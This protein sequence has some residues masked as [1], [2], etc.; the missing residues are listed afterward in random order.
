MRRFKS[1]FSV[2]TALLILSGLVAACSSDA[3][4]RPRPNEGPP[5]TG[6]GSTSFAVTVSSNASELLVGTNATDQQSAI[7]TVSVRRSDNGQ[8][9]PNG[10]TVVVTTN[11]GSFGSPGSGTTSVVLPLTNGGAAI[12]LFGGMVLGT[13]IVQASISGSV[14]SVQIQIVEEVAFALNFL[15]PNSG[16]P[17]GGETVVVNGQGFQ[18]PVQIRFGFRI[19]NPDGSIRFD[20]STAQAVAITPTQVT[21]VTPPSLATVGVGDTAIVN[22]EFTN[23][24]GTANETTRTLEGAF[25]YA[26][27]GTLVRPVISSI[28]PKA[29]PNEG[30]TRI[31]ILGDGFESPVQVIFGNGASPAGFQGVEATIES[32]TRGELVVVTPSATGVGQDNRNSF[33][34]ILV[35]NQSSGFATIEQAGF[36]YGQS[37]VFVSSISPGQGPHFGGT[38]VTI[39]GSGFDEPV[40]VSFA[41]VAASI[42]SVTGSEI[43]ARTSGVVLTSC[44]NVEGPTEVVNIE[45]SDGATGPDFIYVVA[46]PVVSSIVPSDLGQAGGSVTI[47]GVSFEEP[48]QV[49]FGE[50]RGSNAVVSEGGTVIMVDAPS[51]V[52]D[53]PTET[54]TDGSGLAGV[55]SLP[56]AVDVVVENAL[57]TCDDTL[58]EAVIY[59]PD[60]TSCRPAPPIAGFAFTANDTL[61]TFQN[62]SRNATSFSWDFGDG[63]SSGSANPTHDYISVAAGT[64][65]T[66]TVV[67]TA[68]NVT[69]SASA[70]QQVTVTAP[71]P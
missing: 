4:T 69:G 55:R 43:V 63:T 53:F 61:V 40:A 66:F 16:S 31:R 25:T 42:I 62:N 30:G 68:T 48:V 29:G 14:G 57:T 70:S 11:R 59:S 56:V 17:A 49:T 60:D 54:C 32:V 10:T 2:L 71:A 9:P 58:Q 22:I 28:S 21:I 38:V 6:G 37:N 44:N 41:N 19:V 3:P 67:L 36:Q 46:E 8:A 27:G 7:V 52:G 5:P 33:V 24:V 1:A 13:A 47:R 15:D 51:F 18:G 23:R 12:E 35:R 20:T 50:R 65:A 34:N 39:F 45:T 64:T 26:L